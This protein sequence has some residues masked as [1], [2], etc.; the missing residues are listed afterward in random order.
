VDGATAR[1]FAEKPWTAAIRPVQRSRRPGAGELDEDVSTHIPF[2]AV[3]FS[4]VPVSADHRAAVTRAERDE[5]EADRAA[6]QVVPREGKEP[7]G[8]EVPPQ[9]HAGQPLSAQER[10]FFGSRLGHDFSQV[11]IH[12]DSRSAQLADTLNAE[13]FTVGRDIHFGA[14]RRQ[15]GKRA[16]DRLLAHEL[17]HVVQQ[18]DAGPAVQPKLTFTGKEA[19]VA[20]ALA[21]LNG[22]FGSS[23][24]ASVDK[25]GEVKLEP[26]RAAHTSS[27]TGPTAEQRALADRLSTVINDPKDVAMTVS[28]GSTTL[29]GS[30]ATGDF[31]I[32]DLETYG[33]P[34][35][36]HE[37]QEQY[38]KQVKGEAFGTEAAGAHSEAIAAE[39]EVRGA[40]RGAQ[41]M[42]SKTVNADGT[43]DAV[44]EIPHTFP[45]GVVK[46]MVMTVKSNDIVS[47]TW[48]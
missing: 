40:K 13:A 35:L 28:A 29:G 2:F 42:V 5:Q 4:R 24:R 21:L 37:I 47:V 8:P 17:A 16:S 23:Y 33:V 26:I 36:I 34:G 1:A 39:S 41:K 25:S 27:A 38:R 22:G 44:V 15:R 48:K 6:E 20:R 3:D 32:A 11:R 9:S 30:Y 45:G 46:T 10:S 19:D 12:S 14:G 31:D 18:S 43:L 7:S